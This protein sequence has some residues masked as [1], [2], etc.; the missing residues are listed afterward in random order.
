MLTFIKLTDA[1]RLKRA[2]RNQVSLLGM[3]FVQPRDS[4]VAIG[5]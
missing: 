5:R 3:G 2:S 4:V 1:D